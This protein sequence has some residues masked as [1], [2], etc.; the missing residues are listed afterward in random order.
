VLALALTIAACI[1]VLQLAVLAWPSRSVGLG[2][3]MLTVGAGMYGCG[4]LAVLLQFAYTRGVAAVTGDPLFQVVQTASYTV[5]PF[6][7]EVIKILP[8]LLIAVTLRSRIQW[9]IADF[10]L[11][12]AASGAGF[13][14][15]EAVL[16]FGQ[17]TGQAIAVPN[18]WVL[19]TGFAPPFVPDP[20]TSLT[21]WLPAPIS[22]EVLSLP[23]GPDVSVHLAW[24]A[25]A[26]AGIGFLLRT[27]GPTRLLGIVP[28]LLVGADHASYNFDLNLTA[29]SGLGKVLA[30]PFV[31]AQPL[32]GLWPLLAIALALWIDLGHLHHRLAEQPEL[33][34]A[35]E[36]KPVGEQ[37]QS[38]LL[39]R[40]EA[41][42][43][44]TLH[45]PP[46]TALL[47]VRFVRMRR[48]ALFATADPHAA[49]PMLGR[50]RE[51]RA[52]LDSADSAA[53]WRDRGLRDLLGAKAKGDQ[54]PWWRRY[55]PLLAWAVLF[56]P[57]LI[58][59]LLGTT[60]GA[61][62]VQKLLSSTVVFP[63]VAVVALVGLIWTLWGLLAAVRA[64]PAAAREADA[65]ASVRL[66]L[67]IALAAGA[68]AFGV[69]SLVSWLTGTAPNA[70]LISNFHVLDAL[71]DLLLVGGIML[72]L[73]AFIFF[74]PLGLAAVAGGGSVLVLTITSG[75][76]TLGT[77]GLTSIMLSQAVA[78]G[79]GGQF[80]GGSSGG[81][82]NVPDMP[83]EPPA[84][85]PQVRNWRLRNIV[86]NLWKGTENP[87]R[88]GDGTTMDAVRNELQTG[89][90]SNGI[91]HSQ[92]ARESVQALDRWIRDFGPQATR[93]DRLVAWRLRS[94]L[95]NALAGR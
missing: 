45:R 84:P 41:L 55:W 49:E 91:F 10:L 72:L 81:G 18:G 31:A 50:V 58:F 33:L 35:R 83:Q 25:L 68:M 65:S 26:G 17:R 78:S 76:L 92:K 71:S 59:Y 20:T 67:R 32:L 39:S 13:G 42:T 60:P 24:S 28:L 44:Y 79:G 88:I 43:R 19:P 5:D 85:K 73:A 53:A 23:S 3:L 77:L 54:R 51:I 1:G 6:I 70:R 2:T 56:L 11:V 7:E 80:G 37:A 48:A 21:S 64:L 40:I 38:P 52:Q 12:G 63:V 62:G 87:N 86:D 30:A 36:R 15:L 95:L 66:R 34:L 89:R 75:F 90:P 14:L 27:R 57:A 29:K 16:R 74:P 93:E 22:A 4:V 46:W 61:S 47:I 69:V 9:G 8:L 82:S 94:D